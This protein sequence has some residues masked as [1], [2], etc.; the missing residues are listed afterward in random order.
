[1]L[2]L[3]FPHSIGFPFFPFTTHRQSRCLFCLRGIDQLSFSRADTSPVT[4]RFFHLLP[5][6]SLTAFPISTARRALFLF[7][8]GAIKVPPTALSLL[9][10]HPRILERFDPFPDQPFS[11]R[12][13][14]KY[15]NSPSLSPLSRPCTCPFVFFPF[16]IRPCAG[17]YLTPSYTNTPALHPHYGTPLKTILDFPPREPC[18]PSNMAPPS[19]ANTSLLCI[20]PES[21]PP[22]FY[23]VYT[24]N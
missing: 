15:F 23:V 22:L 20:L 14:F 11:P 3:T 2:T 18:F 9:C 5:T 13:I 1:L 8:Q 24:F 19:V 16:L 7:A 21:F 6:P 10:T 17:L 4:S 12:H